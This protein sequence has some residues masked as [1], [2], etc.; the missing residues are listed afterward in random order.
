[1]F[2]S[3]EVREAFQG[4][5]LLNVSVEFRSRIQVLSATETVSPL[6][7]KPGTK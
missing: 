2:S 5:F 4:R 1:M 6:D 3:I 7:A